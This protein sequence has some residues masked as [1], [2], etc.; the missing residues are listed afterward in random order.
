MPAKKLKAFLDSNNI[1]YLSLKHSPAYTAQE[2]AAKYGEDDVAFSYGDRN[3]LIL[4]VLILVATVVLWNV[5]DFGSP[6]YMIPVGAPFIICV[7]IFLVRRLRK[8]PQVER[9]RMTVI[10][11]FSFFVIFFSGAFRGGSPFSRTTACQRHAVTASPK[12][13]H[14]SLNSPIP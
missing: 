8:Y 12:S 3:W 13:P 9:D 11:I 4:S 10:G 2:I 7:L 1:K 5:V 6:L 14:S